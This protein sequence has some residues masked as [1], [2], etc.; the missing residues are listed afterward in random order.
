MLL[1]AAVG[2][3][4]GG[5]LADLHGTMAVV[6]VSLAVLVALTAGLPLA[7][8]LVALPLLVGIGLALDS[9]YYSLVIAAQDALPGR[10]GFASGTV[11]GLSIGIGAGATSLLGHLVDTSGPSAAIATSLGFAVLAMVFALAARLGSR[12]Q[13]LDRSVFALARSNN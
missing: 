5:R 8:P 10:A 3:Y 13:G 4:L 7:T 12:A 11:L 2:S 6:V 1:G 9:A